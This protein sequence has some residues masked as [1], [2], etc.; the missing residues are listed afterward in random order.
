MDDID[1]SGK[2]LADKFTKTVETFALQTCNDMHLVVSPKNAQI[3]AFIL[4]D[5][6]LRVVFQNAKSAEELE[7]LSQMINGRVE[8]LIDQLKTELQIEEEEKKAKENV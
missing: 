7:T 1:A 3:I 8:E 2:E 5:I 6:G 4:A